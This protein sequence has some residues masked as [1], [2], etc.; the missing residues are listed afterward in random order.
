MSQEIKFN[1]IRHFGPSVLHAK[2]PK[3]VI[4]V[5]NRYIDETIKDNEKQKKFKI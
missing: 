2:I 4:E 5:L 3:S 1:L